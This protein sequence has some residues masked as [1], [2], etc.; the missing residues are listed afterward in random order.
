[1]KIYNLIVSF[2][3]KLQQIEREWISIYIL[4]SDMKNVS[5]TSDALN[6]F[7]IFIISIFKAVLI[8]LVC[9]Y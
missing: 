6:L 2:L 5:I 9:K 8:W 7:N 4:V 3:L 1:M